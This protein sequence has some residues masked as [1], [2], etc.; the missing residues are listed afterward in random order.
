MAILNL[1][2]VLYIRGQNKSVRLGPHTKRILRNLMLV[3]DWLHAIID[4]SFVPHGKNEPTKNV[5]SPPKTQSRQILCYTFFCL[6]NLCLQIFSVPMENGA[7]MKRAE[8]QT[9]ILA[10]ICGSRNPSNLSKECGRFF[11]SMKS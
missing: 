3:V 2:L 10:C 11:V 1:G 4:S 7:S 9:W 5:K 8:I 6:I